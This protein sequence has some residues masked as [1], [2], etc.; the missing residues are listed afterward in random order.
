MFCHLHSSGKLACQPH[1]SFREKSK[2]H[3]DRV[4]APLNSVLSQASR[5]PVFI[6]GCVQ[7]QKDQGLSLFWVT[8]T[9]MASFKPRSPFVPTIFLGLRLKFSALWPSFWGW[10]HVPGPCLFF[11][12]CRSAALLGIA[13]S[14]RTS[15]TIQGEQPRISHS[16]L[17][18]G[19]FV[20]HMSEQNFESHVQHKERWR[21]GFKMSFNIKY[22][23]SVV[24]LPRLLPSFLPC[25]FKKDV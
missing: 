24:P 23:N 4:W 11:L 10:T 3:L 7:L 9:R 16:D 20:N 21:Q 13:L 12:Y 18:Q 1:R 5:E 22:A 2:F 15:Q 14:C 25:L 6:T 17:A 19:S 8:S